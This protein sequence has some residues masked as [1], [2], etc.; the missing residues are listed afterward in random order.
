MRRAPA[1][2]SSALSYLTV[3]IDWSADYVARL[4]P[5]GRTLDL[6]GWL[7]L[8]NRSGMSFADAPT[9]VV[10]GALARVAAGPAGAIAP[11]Q[12][13]LA[14]WPN[15]TTTRLDLTPFRRRPP[16]D[17]GAGADAVADATSVVVTA[18]M[19]EQMRW[20]RPRR[21]RC[22][23]SS[24][25]TSSTPWSSRPRWR[26]SRPSR[27]ASCTSRREVRDA[28]RGR[29]NAVDAAANERPLPAA[30]S[31]A[32][33]EQDRQ[34][35][36]ACRCRPARSRCGSRRARPASSTSAS[37]ACATCRRRAVRDRGR[38]GHG[39][40]VARRAW[41]PTLAPA[42][43]RRP[44]AAELAFDADQRQAR[45]GDRRVRQSSS[46]ATGLAVVRRD[47]PRTGP[48]TATTSGAS[49]CR[50]TAPRP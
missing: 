11:K 19:R 44:P 45:P 15:Q 21:G 38:P 23:P 47:R 40:D 42:P 33:R 9:A 1:A 16:P 24:A 13:D 12:L 7:T 8:S 30:I 6:T 36:W 10:A 48:R 27:S 18:E 20:R 17:G 35:G 2:T 4:A 29:A 3:R 32:V 46:G 25:T 43:G 28:L 5:D 14:C 31:A 37:T 49:P 22:R 26:R 39:R 41:S 50:P 34:T